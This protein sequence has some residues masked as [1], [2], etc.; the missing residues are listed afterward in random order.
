MAETLNYSL[1][2]SL[3]W[4]AVPSNWERISDL[5]R[6]TMQGF[7][8][9]HF[10]DSRDDVFVWPLPLLLV[11][12]KPVHVSISS[13]GATIT[14]YYTFKPSHRDGVR[15]PGTLLCADSGSSV[16]V[17]DSPAG[18]P[19]VYLGS[20]MYPSDAD[21]YIFAKPVAYDELAVHAAI[22]S[23]PKYA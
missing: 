12:T 23:T 7:V 15:V 20:N 3:Y 21:A 18:N 22:A 4:E 14:N 1:P 13:N 8:D 19:T 6:I 16:L 2:Q 10:W 9:L 11:D 17:P 5:S